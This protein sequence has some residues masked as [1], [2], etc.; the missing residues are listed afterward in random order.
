MDSR[1]LRVS[2]SNMVFKLPEDST[3]LKKI[4]KYFKLRLLKKISIFPDDKN[5]ANKVLKGYYSKSG[6]PL[7]V[8]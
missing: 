5:L 3:Q 1:E 7:L 2:I 4:W 8:N 6:I